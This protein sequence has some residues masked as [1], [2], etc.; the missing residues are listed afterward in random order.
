M[1]RDAQLNKIHSEIASI[2]IS[3]SR[4]GNAIPL[5]PFA[6]KIAP[7]LV[8]YQTNKSNLELARPVEF[9]FKA[10]KTALNQFSKLPERYQ[11]AAIEE[12]LVSKLPI[13]KKLRK[14]YSTQHLKRLLLFKLVS[15]L[16]A[17]GL[18]KNKAYEVIQEIMGCIGE[19]DVGALSIKQ[20][21]RRVINFYTFHY[22]ELKTIPPQ[23]RFNEIHAKLDAHLRVL[24]LPRSTYDGNF[25]QAITY[26]TNVTPSGILNDLRFFAGANHS[27]SYVWCGYLLSKQPL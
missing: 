9:Y 25:L 3:A 22:P 19:K 1:N 11:F 15:L 6:S 21:I 27:V 13:A 5:K 26:N 14:F 24:L 2:V 20:H 8:D 4:S 12:D 10:L 7:L 23:E 18:S 16:S 17:E